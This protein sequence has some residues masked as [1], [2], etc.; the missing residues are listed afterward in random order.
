MKTMSMLSRHAH[1]LFAKLAFSGVDANS[2]AGPFGHA[3]GRPFLRYDNIKITPSREGARV[4]F[5]W[6]G[7][8]MAWIAFPRYRPELGDTLSLTGIEGRMT[9]SV[10]DAP[11]MSAPTP[12]R[13]VQAPRVAAAPAPRASSTPWGERVRAML[14][15]FSPLS[16]TRPVPPANRSRLL[17]TPPEAQV[18]RAAPASP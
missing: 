18:L 7:T 16:S 17:A 11:P 2:T 6:R 13:P 1:D 8:E 14:A 10:D 5:M 15:L 12:P 9:V 3:E 4:L